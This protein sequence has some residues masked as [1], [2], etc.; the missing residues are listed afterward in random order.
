VTGIVAEPELE[1]TC[2]E[3]VYVPTARLPG[4]AE[5]LMVPGVV[6]LVRLTESHDAPETASV[7]LSALPLLATV[8]F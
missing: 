5:T 6:P 4:L 3:P 7:K 2:T 1:D 8:K